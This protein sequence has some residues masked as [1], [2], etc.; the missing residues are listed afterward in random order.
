MFVDAQLILSRDKIVSLLP[1]HWKLLVWL[2]ERTNQEFI[3]G[4]QSR[5]YG[6]K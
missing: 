5:H 1:G 4:W 2:L 6:L 3:S